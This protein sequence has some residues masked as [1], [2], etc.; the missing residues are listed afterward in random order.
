MN[1]KAYVDG[2]YNKNTGE[3]SFGAVIIM[4]NKE[5]VKTAKKF[6]K[7]DKYKDSWNVAGE[8][9]GASFVINN[10]YKMGFKELDLYYDYE[11]IEKWY[12]GLWKAKKD[13]SKDYRKFALDMEGKIIVN[14]HKVKAHSGVEYNELADRLAK[15]VIT[16]NSTHTLSYNSKGKHKLR[17]FA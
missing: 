4:P 13:I 12:K 6:D 2:S 14:F 1:V 10:V 3:Y 15:S 7:N 9:R 5:I 11:G 17:T 16:E 8:I